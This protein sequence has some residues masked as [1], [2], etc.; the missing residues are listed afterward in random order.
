MSEGFLVIGAGL[1]RTGTQSTRLA[2]KQLLGSDCYHGWTLIEERDD[3]H[4]HFYKALRG[5]ATKEDWREVLKDYKAGLDLPINLFYK[6]LMEVFPEAKVLLTVR[7]PMSWYISV[8][9]S[10]G[11]FHNIE[12]LWPY[13][14][15]LS[16]AGKK[17]GTDVVREM[18]LKQGAYAAVNAGEESGVK[19]WED[20]VK[21]VIEHVPREKLL[22]WNVKEGWGPLC[23]FLDVPVPDAPFP[24]LNETR[25]IQ[26]I[27]NTLKVSSWLVFFVIPVLLAVLGY[28]CSENPFLFIMAVSAGLFAAF[29]VRQNMKGNVKTHVKKVT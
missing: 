20:H 7:D 6:E 13:S 5:E 23:Q 19:F 28:L 2:L 26:T 29:V 21:D 8:R 11:R 1:S 18:S 24:R 27:V 16:F 12:N 25:E 10:I 9:D 22:V 3:H 4:Q 15:F 17:G 14:W